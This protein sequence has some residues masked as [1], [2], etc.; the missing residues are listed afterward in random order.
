[1]VERNQDQPGAQAGA[2]ASASAHARTGGRLRTGL[3]LGG[4]L[5]TALFLGYAVGP[6]VRPPA[7]TSGLR[8]GLPEPVVPASLDELD[9]WL[10]QSEAKVP[11]LR[12]EL[13]KGIVWASERRERTPLSLVYL[14]GFSASRRESSP[15]CEE[16]GRKLGANVFFARLHGHAQDSEAMG[17]AQ[18]IDWY[19]DALEALAIGAR[20]GEK[21]VLIGTSTG[22]TLA[23]WLAARTPG[24]HAVIL[25]SPNFGLKGTGSS[26]LL[27]PWGLQLARRVI[28]THRTWQPANE[29]EARY[30]TSSYRV[31][32]VLQLAATVEVLSSVDLTAVTTPTQIFYTE[33][34]EL[35]DVERIRTRFAEL[36]S[37]QKQLI[38]I[39]GGHHILVGDVL[40]PANTEPVAKQILEFLGTLKK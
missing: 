35:L 19:N 21:V 20:I 14:H 7:L 23:T 5:L 27:R 8:G 24:V 11:A 9:G 22:G 31:E 38:A 28:G 34:D 33:S 3:L 25:L 39:P 37:A 1:M 15:L 17:Q 4:G 30:W 40:A 36:G 16:L 32:V 6:R 29:L 13:A 18:A 12:P 2:Q 26:L 10:A